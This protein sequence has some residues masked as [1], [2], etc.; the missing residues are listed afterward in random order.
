MF[1]TNFADNVINEV[2]SYYTDE[3]RIS[4][5]V[6]D[7]YNKSPGKKDRE[8]CPYYCKKLD[9]LYSNDIEQYVNATSTKNDKYWDSCADEL[10]KQLLKIV[11][12]NDDLTDEEKKMLNNII[13]EKI[14]AT[15]EH[16]RFKVDNTLAIKVNTFLWFFKS[17]KINNKIAKDEYRNRLIAELSEKNKTISTENE[18]AFSNWLTKMINVLEKE[19][20]SLNPKLRDLNEKLG[21][22]ERLI[23]DLNG[24]RNLIKTEANK[25]NALFESVEVEL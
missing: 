9:Q 5:I 20:D 24:Q 23:D 17:Y 7:A 8:K 3:K 21:E 15:K 25:I 10:K 13:Q 14:Y 18:T 12:E 22:Y 16:K 19:V 11:K 6:D 4:S 2:V 1:S